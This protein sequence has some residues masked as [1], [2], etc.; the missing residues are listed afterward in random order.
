MADERNFRLLYYEQLGLRNVDQVKA[1][2]H[3]LRDEKLDLEKLS[4]FALKFTLPSLYR[5]FVWKVLLGILPS[6]QTSQK[7][8][9][10]H[11]TEQF[12]DLEDALLLMRMISKEDKAIQEKILWMYLLENGLISMAERET[13]Q[14]DEKKIQIF[15]AIANVCCE[16]A[17]HEIDAYWITKK[18]FEMQDKF[19]DVYS[20]L[21]KFVTF[22]LE[23]EDRALFEH[24]NELQVFKVMPYNRWYES[25]FAEIFPTSS[26]ERIWDKLV[27][28]S[29][30]ILVFVC[31]AILLS[32]RLRLLG[33]TRA[34]ESIHILWTTPKDRDRQHMIVDQSLQ[35]WDKHRSTLSVELVSHQLEIGDSITKN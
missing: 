22:Y 12:K 23:I 1:L 17:E 33:S 29:C 19:V 32:C 6:H 9:E 2:E 7:F 14:R 27:A 10:Q 21:P 8:A 3:L 24:M 16:V 4:T 11:R 13:L 15:K 20:K 30:N 31:V 34:E 18:F 25:C 26:L 35:L 28:G 5:P